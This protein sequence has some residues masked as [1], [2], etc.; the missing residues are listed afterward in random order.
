MINEKEVPL[1]IDGV[2]VKRLPPHPTQDP[3]LLFDRWN[4]DENF[5]N[6][7][8][9]TLMNKAGLGAEFFRHFPHEQLTYEEKFAK[10]RAELLSSKEETED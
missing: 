7:Q 8:A 2:E 9:G 3:E 5:G 4:F 6:R 1:I 10:L